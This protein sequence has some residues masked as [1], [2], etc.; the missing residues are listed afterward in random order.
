VPTVK[1]A[2]GGAKAT[3]ATIDRALGRVLDPLAD[4]M[5]RRLRR[6]AERLERQQT[7][8]TGQLAAVLFLFATILYGTIAGGQVGRLADAALVLVGFGI[9]NIE[10]AGQAETSQQAI[11]AKLEVH[12]S[13]V[14]YDAAKAQERIAELAWVERA[15]VRKFYPNRLSVSIVERTPFALWQRDGEV[16]LVDK[17]GVEFGKLQDPRFGKLPLLVGPGANAAAA[18]FLAALQAEPAIASRMRAAVYVAERR[19][20][21]YLEDGVTVKLPEKGMREALAQLV[22]LDAE[23]QILSRDVVVVDLRLPDRV[24]VRLPEGRSLDDVTSQG[25]ADAAI[26]RART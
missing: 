11:L 3:V 16:H 19:W 6:F 18:V 24:T 10:I 7:R 8:F 22:K 12:G 20:D 2:G 4:L 9:Q 26:P 5:P 23:R 17:G 14:N 1:R 25:A 13:L 21:L 15:N